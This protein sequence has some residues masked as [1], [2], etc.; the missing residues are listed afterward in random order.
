MN[1][2][3]PPPLVDRRNPALQSIDV[4]F[5]LSRLGHGGA[6]RRRLVVAGKPSRTFGHCGFDRLA[7]LRC[8]VRYHAYIRILKS[9]CRA[10]IQERILGNVVSGTTP[11]SPEASIKYKVGA[12][13]QPREWA[14]NG[15]DEFISRV[16]VFDTQCAIF[17]LTEKADVAFRPFGLDLFDKLVQACKAVRAKL[18]TEQRALSVS[19]LNAIQAQIPDGTAAARLLATVSSLTKPETVRALAQL[20]PEEGVWLATLERSLVDLQTNDPKKLA[21]QL[22]LRAG[23]IRALARHVK[24]VETTLSPKAI[25]DVIAIRAGGYRKAEEAKRLRDGAFPANVLAGTGSETWT[26]LW[27]AARQF[28]QDCAYSDQPFPVV[29]DGAHCVLC[30]QNLDHAASHRLKQFETFVASSTERELRQLRDIFAQLRR[31][32]TDIE[33]TTE[34]INDVIKET[35]PAVLTGTSS[36]VSG[37]MSRCSASPYAAL[38]TSVNAS[39]SSSDSSPFNMRRRKASRCQSGRS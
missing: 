1:S 9:A 3:S 13:L 21:E 29:E 38:Q 25:G 37:A 22:N 11:L 2:V 14:G 20:S 28:S 18:E 26:A 10:R 24:K 39:I 34:A 35:L 31:T 32:F 33:I 15:E 6:C 4:L 19:A 7:I 27:E 36:S 30:Q 12:E 8:N 23:R 5:K 16:S 17:Y